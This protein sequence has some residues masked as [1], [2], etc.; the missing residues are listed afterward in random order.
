MEIIKLLFPREDP[1][2]G[3][4]FENWQLSQNSKSQQMFM[5]FVSQDSSIEP[6]VKRSIQERIQL[7]SLLRINRILSK[8]VY[9]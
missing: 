4:L 1:K 2:F 3:V 9:K 7:S 5:F 6:T 8:C